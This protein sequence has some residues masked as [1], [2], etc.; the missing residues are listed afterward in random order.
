[1]MKLMETEEQAAEEGIEA[2]ESFMT[3]DDKGNLENIEVD[4]VK[5]RGAAYVAS[6]IHE[7][8]L[9]LKQLFFLGMD[10]KETLVNKG[11]CSPVD[12]LQFAMEKKL[13]LGPE[14]KD[15]IVM[16]H[17]I[18]FTVD[19]RQSTVSSTLIVEG[20]N[21]LRT[22]MAKTVGLPLGIAA[23]LILNGKINLKGLHIPTKKEIYEPVLKEL[24][25]YGIRFTEE[26]L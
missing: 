5:N 11:L 12:V 24:E 10:D 14:E 9:T 17:E 16:M 13:V 21:N 8:N 26:K 15:M 18:Q 25:E 19:S 1:L 4:D 20:E 3:A 7:A 6:K 23:K 22:A 2:P